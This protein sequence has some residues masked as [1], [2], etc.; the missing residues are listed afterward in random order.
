MELS[1]CIVNTNGREDLLAC[2]EAIHRT[3]P[4]GVSYEILVLDNASDDGSAE[5]V[6]GAF[7][8]VR[9]L[10]QDRRAGISANLNRVVAEAQ[11]RFCL[12]LNEDS[13]VTEGAAAALLDAMDADPRAGAAGAMLLDRDGRETACAWRLPDLGSVVASALFLH[14]WLVTQSGG[15]GTRQV[16]WVRSAAIMIRPE[17]GGEVG[18]FDPNFFFYGEECDF[19]KR[20][21][22][23]GWHVLHV[24][25]ARVIHDEG[26]RFAPRRIGQFHRGRDQYMRKHHSMA[27]V[28]ASRVLW[29]WSYAARALAAMVLPG[30]DARGYWFHA[31]CALRPRSREGMRE[32][33][34]AYNRRRAAT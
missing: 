25:A 7:P 23:E 4:A 16:G 10:T 9:V 17:A 26:D 3:H 5:A 34:E 33:A 2:L 11:G 29:S 14:R 31:R 30:H 27:V 12:S 20:L 8:D 1:Y 19:Q 28:A 32:A 15:G 24:P 13:F 21:H 6:R 22:D 18:W